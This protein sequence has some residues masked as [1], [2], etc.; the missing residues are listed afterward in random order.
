MKKFIVLGSGTSGLIAAT[1]IKR[2]W[3]DKVQVSL[4]YDAKKKNIGVGESTT[5]TIHYFLKEYLKVDI[6]EFLRDTGSTVKLGISFREWIKGTDYFHGFPS[7]D[8]STDH[9]PESLYSILTDQY[10]GGS[11]T[12]D[13]TKQ[14]SVGLPPAAGLRRH[15]GPCRHP[16]LG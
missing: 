4:Y 13:A 10:D 3:R 7:T 2:R 6:H 16:S 11:N 12:N 9:Y 1:M 5:P 14:R 15:R 8:V